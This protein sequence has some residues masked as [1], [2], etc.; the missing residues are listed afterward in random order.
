MPLISIITVV[1]N[2]EKT[3]E[4]TILSVIDQTY[5]SIEYIIID[6]ASSDGTIEIIKKY[7][8]NIAY[9]ISEPD[10]G[11]YDAMNKGIAQA[12]G[13]L[14][15]I[16]NSD[17]W[18]EKDAINVIV[19]K[20]LVVK[21]VG[22][23]C[24]NMRLIQNKEVRVLRNGNIHSIIR[25]MVINHPSCFVQRDVYKMLGC[26]STNYKIASDYDFLLRAYLSGTSFLFINKIISNMYFGGVSTTNYI[27]CWMEEKNILIESGFSWIYAEY[28]FLLKVVK[29]SV[30][31][32]LRKYFPP[33]V[34]IINYIRFDKSPT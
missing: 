14:I 3:L 23:Y 16:I 25:G 18:Y 11:I 19:Q 13:D 6:G 2:G 22:I 5:Q 33:L 17:D 10:R 15:G 34:T 29:R 24:G 26:F 4:R 8:K 1:R 31:N 7:E 20:Y 9:W 30:M 27:E 21:T 28:Y 32:F 12:H